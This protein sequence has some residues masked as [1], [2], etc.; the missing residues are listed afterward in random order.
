MINYSTNINKDNNH[1]SPQIIE[2]NKTRHTTLYILP[3]YTIVYIL[4]QYTMVN[5]TYNV[6]YITTIYYGVY[7]TII[8]LFFLT[9]YDFFTFR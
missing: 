1:L 5:T 6:V 9:K 3:Q 4:P 2:H 8:C 7:I